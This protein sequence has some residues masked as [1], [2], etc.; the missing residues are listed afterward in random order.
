MSLTIRL[1]LAVMRPGPRLE[2][3]SGDPQSPRMT[4]YPTLAKYTRIDWSLRYKYITLLT[5]GF[6]PEGG[7]GIM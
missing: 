3:G 6:L 7:E 5:E 2:P 1:S 4:N